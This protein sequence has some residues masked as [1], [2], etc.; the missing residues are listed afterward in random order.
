MKITGSCRK[1]GEY[2]S[3]NVLPGTEDS[4]LADYKEW[5]Q[6]HDH[7]QVTEPV[8]RKPGRSKKLKEPV[9]HE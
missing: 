1:C 3:L 4:A 6:R 9:S 2:F 7:K 5:T 8:K